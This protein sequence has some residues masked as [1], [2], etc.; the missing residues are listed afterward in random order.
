MEKLDWVRE[1]VQAEQQMEE[2]GVVDFNSVHSDELNLK[3]ET[4]SFL[5]DLK[6]VFIEYVSE[7]NQLKGSQI[8]RVKIYGI[9]Q[10]DADFML[11][12]NGFK[13]IFTM[14][15]PGRVAIIFS[16]LATSFL[17][18]N[19]ASE[20]PATTLQEEMLEAQVGAFLKVSWSYQ[21][22]PFNTDNMVRY[23]LTRFIKE[24][25]R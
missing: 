24:S 14:R 17:G 15:E 7:F 3:D 25:A 22:Q 4:V 9:S 23:Y 18:L 13:L 20:T 8:G 11:F 2:S 5:K 12:R 6:N 1:L 10:T 21:G 16:F 19:K